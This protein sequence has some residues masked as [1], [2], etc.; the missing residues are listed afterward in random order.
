MAKKFDVDDEFEYHLENNPKSHKPVK[1]LKVA[2]K[3]ASKK[4]DGKHRIN[5]I[6]RDDD[7]DEWDK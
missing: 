3:K 4:I 7:F 2:L 1:G 6:Y 5:D